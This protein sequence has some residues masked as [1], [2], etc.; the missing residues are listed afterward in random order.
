[1][2]K[3]KIV[4][5][6]HQSWLAALAKAK[7]Q[8]EAADLTIPDWA[9]CGITLDIPK[10][11]CVSRYGHLYDRSA[12]ETWLQKSNKDP[13]TKK[14]LGIG[15]LY[16]NPPLQFLVDYT[17]S[18]PNDS[19]DSKLV[20]SL[21]QRAFF[22]N[23]LI[24]GY[25][26]VKDNDRS[27]RKLAGFP[28]VQVLFDECMFP[29][30]VL[31]HLFFDT[32]QWGSFE[33]RMAGLSRLV[34]HF[35]HLTP[36]SEI[37]SQ[38]PSRLSISR[39]CTSNIFGTRSMDIFE[40]L[41]SAFIRRNNHSPYLNIL[42]TFLEMLAGIAAPVAT[43]LL[44]N[45]AKSPGSLPQDFDR[46]FQD[47]IKKYGDLNQPVDFPQL[48]N[49]LPL[50]NS[51]INRVEKVEHHQPAVFNR[52]RGLAIQGPESNDPPRWRKFL[53][54]GGAAFSYLYYPY[55]VLMQPSYQQKIHQS[56]GQFLTGTSDI[57]TRLDFTADAMIGA[58]WGGEMV[59]EMSCQSGLSIVARDVTGKGL[60]AVLSAAELESA[61]N[62]N[63]DMQP[64]R[65]NNSM[66]LPISQALILLVGVFYFVAALMQIWGRDYSPP[67]RAPR[68][69]GR[70]PRPHRE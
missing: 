13:L 56:L 47:A 61:N 19:Q 69:R 32:Q 23:A 26:V 30:H 39:N 36:L 7:A 4:A 40:Y 59:K 67:P 66:W 45:Y 60:K 65:E 57:L 22:I 63:M 48:Q 10:D 9:K 5:S 6:P 12:I 2:I 20:E 18:V 35:P 70:D 41:S 1:M 54:T 8:I 3:T 51:W 58:S 16:P 21:A 37:A 53:A 25:H 34:S 11:V 24:V 52:V 28:C 42:S 49:N 38:N 68:G 27:E 31:T 62:L 50:S 46:S 44:Q 14:T 33:W 29:L 55:T 43:W 64:P 15:D 17:C